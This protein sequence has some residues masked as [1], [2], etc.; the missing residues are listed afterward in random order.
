MSL[1]DTGETEVTNGECPRCNEGLQAVTTRGP[2]KHI[3]Q[4]CGCLLSTFETDRVT[5]GDA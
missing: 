1:V 4:P 5:R 2:G 3:A